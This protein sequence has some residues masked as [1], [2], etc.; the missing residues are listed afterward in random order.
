MNLVVWASFL[1][2][3]VVMTPAPFSV[4]AMDNIYFLLWLFLVTSFVQFV[5]KFPV[6]SQFLT[7]ILN[8]SL[9]CVLVRLF[10]VMCV[11]ELVCCVAGSFPVSLFLVFLSFLVWYQSNLHQFL[12]HQETPT[13]LNSANLYKTMEMYLLYESLCPQ[14]SFTFLWPKEIKTTHDS[15][16]HTIIRNRSTSDRDDDA[17]RPPLQE[18][19]FVCVFLAAGEDETSSSPHPDTYTLMWNMNVGRKPKHWQGNSRMRVLEEI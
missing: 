8:V 13:P 9:N 14:L 10:S 19:V 5:F 7:Y 6:S 18:S 4:F 3:T 2:S 11:P 17:A 12:F 1:T 15:L 16:S